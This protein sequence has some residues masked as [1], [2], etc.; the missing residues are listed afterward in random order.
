MS[1]QSLHI[2][3]VEDSLAEARFLQEILKGTL[4]GHCCLVH[5]TRLQDAFLKL[6]EHTFHVILLDLTLPDS[7]GRS[8]ATRCLRLSGETARQW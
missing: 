7:H 6:E 2:L 1:G 5:V 3:L 4:L 8:S